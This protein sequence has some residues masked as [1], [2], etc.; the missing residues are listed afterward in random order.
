VRDHP[1]G[2]PCE[3][4]SDS[5]ICRG[6]ARILEDLDERLDALNAFNRA[7]RPDAEDLTADRFARC[8]TVVIEVQEMSGRRERDGDVTKWRWSTG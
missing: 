3:V 2:K 8:A 1:G 7:F 4:D 5:V 6:T